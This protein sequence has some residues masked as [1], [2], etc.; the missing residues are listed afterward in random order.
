LPTKNVPL[1][2][3]A[4]IFIILAILLSFA[5]IFNFYLNKSSHRETQAT[6]SEPLPIPFDYNMSISP[7]NLRVMQGNEGQANVTV[8]Y[9]QGVPVNIS[10]NAV[11]VPLSS[12]YSFSKFEQLPSNN[13]TFNSIFTIYVPESVAANSYNITINSLADNGKSYSELCTLSVIA[14]QVSMTG[15]VTTNMGRVPTQITFYLLWDPNA[16]VQTFTAPIQ[17]GEYQ[18]SLP[19]YRFFAVSVDW[20]AADG[21]SGKNNF[22][23]PFSTTSGAT[24]LNC[25]FSWEDYSNEG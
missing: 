4:I 15:T 18:I 5:L 8:T 1:S 11:D 19:N 13:H 20:K 7:T 24:S 3:N 21:S 10:M 22:I 6:N 17:S 9:L 23:Q 16:S 12:N 25:P 14:S 2:R